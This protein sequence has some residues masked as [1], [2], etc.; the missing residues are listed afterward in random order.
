MFPPVYQ[1]S[2]GKYPAVPELNSLSTSEG[3]LIKFLKILLDIFLLNEYTLL[4][5]LINAHTVWS[6][7]SILFFFRLRMIQY[8]Q[9]SAVNLGRYA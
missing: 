6:L 3:N 1:D 2:S 5:L 8:F 4:V 9:D 7:S